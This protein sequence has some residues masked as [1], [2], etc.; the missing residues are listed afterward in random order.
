VAGRE[1]QVWPQIFEAGTARPSKRL[2]HHDF[3]IYLARLRANEVL[4]KIG[5]PHFGPN[6]SQVHAQ[7]CSGTGQGPARVGK[8]KVRSPSAK[9]AMGQECMRHRT[10]SERRLT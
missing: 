7:A 8:E 3:M 6:R 1:D 5:I 4:L 10:V 2:R 9:R